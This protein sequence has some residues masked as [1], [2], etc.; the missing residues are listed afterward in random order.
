MAAFRSP[1]L[2]LPFV[3]NGTHDIAFASI[4]FAIVTSALCGGAY[5][6][7]NKLYNMVPKS[8]REHIKVEK[9]AKED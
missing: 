3:K 9:L 1:T 5:H 2:Y 6:I 4:C 7:F 8:E